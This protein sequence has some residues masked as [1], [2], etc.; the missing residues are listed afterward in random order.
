[1]TFPSLLTFLNYGL[2]LIY[3][4]LISTWISGGCSTNREKRLIGFA[5]P[6]LLLLQGICSKVFGVVTVQ[7]L[8]PLITHLPLLLILIIGLK[9]SFWTAL[10]SVCTA[11]LCCQLPRWVSLLLELT[12]I[13]LISE[14]GYTLSIVPIGVLLR[15]F[16]VPAA[17]DA[18]SYST[19]NLILFGSL[20]LL[21]Y[22][23]DYAAV[24]YSDALYIG[25]PALVE[26]LPTALIAFYVVFLTAYHKQ[27]QRRTQAE[28]QRSILEAELKQSGEQIEALRRMETQT[29]IYQHDMRHHLGILESYI[30]AGRPEQA[31]EYIRKVQQDVEAVAPKHF[32]SNEPVNLLCSSFSAKAQRAG[33]DFT[34][35][36]DIGSS[37]SLTDTE[38]CSLISNALDNAF[39]A[40]CQL[41]EQMRWV[42]FIAEERRNKLLLEVRNP[43]SGEILM[44]DGLPVTDKQGHGY[45]C[46]SIQSIVQKY[47]G[48]YSFQPSKGIFTLRIVLPL[49]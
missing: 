44:R 20:P 43:Y 38:L 22:A 16:F 36:A 26:T 5:C 1:M 35:R 12:G 34:I 13:P 41:P 15:K 24:I 7:R 11:Y 8:Y 19:Q 47:S 49:R 28:L 29:A 4:L 31:Q 42:E 45:G 17:R 23:F 9:R 39:G 27:T 3:G 48:L 14:I 25:I 10:I 21:Y 40:V 32:C 2:V 37:L 6:V 46:L 18:M 30:A 33:I